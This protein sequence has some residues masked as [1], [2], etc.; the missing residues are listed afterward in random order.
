M[1]KA[2]R[3]EAIHGTEKWLPDVFNHGRRKERL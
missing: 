3:S 2:K 1:A